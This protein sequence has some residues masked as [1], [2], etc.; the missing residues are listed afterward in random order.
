L[1]SR[2]A[3]VVVCTGSAWP[4]EGET[5]LARTSNAAPCGRRR[6]LEDFMVRAAGKPARNV[7]CS[8]FDVCLLT[9]TVKTRY[10]DVDVYCWV[11]RMSLLGM[12]DVGGTRDGQEF[13]VADARAR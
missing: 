7:P 5:T 9:I 4:D 3:T 6:L 12:F 8:K 2:Y 10:R 13:D 1:R 11:V